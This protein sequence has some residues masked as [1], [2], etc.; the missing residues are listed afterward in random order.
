MGTF[1]SKDDA[2]PPERDLAKKCFFFFHVF[3]NITPFFFTRN[4]N[5]VIFIEE[6]K[7]SPDRNIRKLATFDNHFS[8]KLL[9]G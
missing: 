9:V 1:R 7:P 5:K 2:R 3:L 6:V 8:L 4:V